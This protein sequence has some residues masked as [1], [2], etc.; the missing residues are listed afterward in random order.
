[1]LIG[2]RPLS[3]P[4]SVPVVPHIEATSDLALG[5]TFIVGEIVPA[6]A[7]F[8]DLALEGAF[9]FRVWQKLFGPVVFVIKNEPERIVVLAEGI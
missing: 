2:A 7:A 6:R 4:A 8:S 5:G 1:M 3:Y 9:T